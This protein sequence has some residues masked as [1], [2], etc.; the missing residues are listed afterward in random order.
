MQS[1][2]NLGNYNFL[3]QKL[4]TS[5]FNQISTIT[6]NTKYKSGEVQICNGTLGWGIRKNILHRANLFFRGGSK[7]KKVIP[8]GGKREER[9]SCLSNSQLWKSRFDGA[10]LIFEPPRKN[11]LS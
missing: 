1:L 3:V 7:I 9:P 11:E 10:N 4:V 5:Y 6:A 2:Q 8:R